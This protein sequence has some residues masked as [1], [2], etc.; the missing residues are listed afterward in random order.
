MCQS[1]IPPIKKTAE[2][3]KLGSKY[4][5]TPKSLGQILK[6]LFSL[7]LGRGPEKHSSPSHD[8]SWNPFLIADE[9]GGGGRGAPEPG[10]SGGSGG[11][12]PPLWVSNPALEGN[13]GVAGNAR[14]VLLFLLKGG[15]GGS[16]PGSR[17]RD[18]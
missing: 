3:S 18:K 10:L 5:V 15:G 12:T 13:C 1:G 17:E 14:E 16:G 2:N 11:L 6:Y 4:H 9:G 8:E 7:Y